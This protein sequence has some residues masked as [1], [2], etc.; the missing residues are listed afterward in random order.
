MGRRTD[1]LGP[2]SALMLQK[3]LG[4]VP[5]E[6]GPRFPASSVAAKVIR[7]WLV[8]GLQNDAPGLATLP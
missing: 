5:H 7:S 1:R 3:A 4:R 6:G 8:E 2:D